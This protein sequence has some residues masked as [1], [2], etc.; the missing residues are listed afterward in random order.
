MKD[1]YLEVV[2]DS[3][4][5]RSKEQIL[6]DGRHFSRDIIRELLV[7]VLVLLVLLLL[8]IATGRHLTGAENALRRLRIGWQEPDEIAC[9]VAELRMLQPRSQVGQ[10]AQERIGLAVT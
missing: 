7:L 5:G 2:E 8:W 10:L 4:R 3:G 1:K 6:Q 9:R